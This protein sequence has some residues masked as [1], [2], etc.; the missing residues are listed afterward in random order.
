[1]H[2]LILYFH[3]LFILSAVDEDAVWKAAKKIQSEAVRSYN[4]QQYAEAE[5]KFRDVFEVMKM[6]FHPQHPEYIKAEKSC[7]MVQRKRSQM[8][9]YARPGSARGYGY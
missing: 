4:N 3:A 8:S 6:L 7:L 2:P 9:E 1:M 5:E